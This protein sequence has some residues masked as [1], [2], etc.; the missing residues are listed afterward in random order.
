MSSITFS[1]CD[2][3]KAE[4]SCRMQVIHSNF[5]I[6]ADGTKEFCPLE[7]F[8][9]LSYIGLDDLCPKFIFQGW[10]A[11]VHAMFSQKILPMCHDRESQGKGF[12]R[13]TIKDKMWS[14]VRRAFLRTLSLLSDPCLFLRWAA[15]LSEP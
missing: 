13:G 8:S 6:I 4:R 3:G 5:L 7:Q 14:T 9:W 15:G 10:D 12:R 11:A 1:R 2:E